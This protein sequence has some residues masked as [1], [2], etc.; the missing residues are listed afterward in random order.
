MGES[1]GQDRQRRRLPGDLMAPVILLVAIGGWF[2][3][4]QQ[5]VII[6][7]ATATVAPTAAPTVALGDPVATPAGLPGLATPWSAA[8]PVTPPPVV[9][10]P[11]VPEPIAL[12]GPPAGASFR[13]GDVVSFYWAWPHSL[14]ATQRFALYGATGESLQL[15]GTVAEAN[16]GTLYQLQVPVEEFG[17]EAG[18]YQWWIVL[19]DEASAGTIGA[20]EPRPLA[21]VGG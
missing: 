11:V 5:P 20:S 9:A 18:S 1:G 21:I 13:A 10:T 19:E 8:E 2:W 3:L 15:L 6:S 7:Q 4:A 17:E 14:T 12:L 16:L